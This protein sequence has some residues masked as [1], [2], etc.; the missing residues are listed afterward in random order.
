MSVTSPTS[1]E[2]PEGGPPRPMTAEEAE[3]RA[4]W[5]ETFQRLTLRIG[6]LACAAVVV[7]LPSGDETIGTA[8]HVGEG[9]Y[10][11]AR[12]VVKGNEVLTLI[13]HSCGWI[14]RD[15]LTVEARTQGLLNGRIPIWNMRHPN[16]QITRGPFFHK[17][18]N[19]DVAAF[20]ASGVDQNTPTLTLGHHYDDWIVDRDW[21]LT[22]GTV[23]G[24]PPIPTASRPI[25]LAATVEVNAVVDTYRDR[26]VRFV[27][28]GPPRGGFSG[29]PVFHSSGFVLGMV[30]ES[31]EY[32]GH[33][34]SG[35]FTVL[36]IE[37]LHETLDQHG[38]TPAS[39]ALPTPEE[40]VAIARAE[41][42][43]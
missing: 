26:Y 3:A 9:V 35:F 18:K 36:S 33:P 31:L 25:Q 39:Q 1:E 5:Q 2:W 4:E 17:D 15:E 30:I 32:L 23:F 16:P 38:L 12:H 10:M 43:S 37:A 28:S 7:R 24:Y 29:G 42:E 27:V 40:A 14:F 21:L 6:S 13:P 20:V 8:F 41:L 34:E 22:T 11:T 19:V